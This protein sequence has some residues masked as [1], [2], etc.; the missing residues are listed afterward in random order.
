MSLFSAPG[1]VLIKIT[2]LK[3]MQRHFSQHT[4]LTLIKISTD[5]SRWQTAQCSDDRSRS[6]YTS[7]KAYGNLVLQAT[8]PWA[9][10]LGPWLVLF[11]ENVLLLQW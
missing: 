5:N 8:L 3:S 6:L 4:D 9:K 11:L 2:L 7:G 1:S 10:K